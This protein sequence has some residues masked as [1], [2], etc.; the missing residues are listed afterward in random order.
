VI[1]NAQTGQKRV[2]TDPAPPMVGRLTTS[3]IKDV[4]LPMELGSGHYRVF[5]QFSDNGKIVGQ[6]RFLE[7]DI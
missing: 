5:L 6:S 3:G 7:L 1:E 4:T 2:V